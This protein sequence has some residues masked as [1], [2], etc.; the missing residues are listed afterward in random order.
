M[1]Y[2]LLG[3]RELCKSSETSSDI[4][5]T[6]S[7]PIVFTEAVAW[8]TEA[9]SGQHSDTCTGINSPARRDFAKIGNLSHVQPAH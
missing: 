3:A 8:R 4:D 6:I 9:T 7:R 2:I 5:F 1:E